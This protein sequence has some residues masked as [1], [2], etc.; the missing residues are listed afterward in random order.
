M[1]TYA[2]AYRQLSEQ[3]QQQRQTRGIDPGVPILQPI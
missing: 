3:E 1:L 2:D